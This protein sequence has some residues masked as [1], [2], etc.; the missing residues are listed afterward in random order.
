MND[1]IKSITMIGAVIIGLTAQ[2]VMI[3]FL[4]ECAWGETGNRTNNAV[5]AIFSLLLS[6][7]MDGIVR[8]LK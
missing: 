1:A 2:L 5:M 4:W 6:I 7:K 3:L 8:A